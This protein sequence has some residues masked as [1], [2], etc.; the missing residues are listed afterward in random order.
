[1]AAEA[2]KGAKR[3]RLLLSEK[4]LLARVH[5]DCGGLRLSPADALLV[6]ARPR[7]KYK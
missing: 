7:K 1:V 6:G 4:R 3:P 5:A 2:A